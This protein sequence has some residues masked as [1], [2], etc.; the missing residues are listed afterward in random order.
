MPSKPVA[1]RNFSLVMWEAPPIS[2]GAVGDLS[3]SR[4]G[5]GHELLHGPLSPWKAA[6]TSAVPRSAIGVTPAKSPIG[7]YDKL[8]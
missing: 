2:G 6:V 4:L 7:S 3:G 1:V 5:V 8:A